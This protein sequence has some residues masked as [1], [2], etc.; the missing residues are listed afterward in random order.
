[1]S[2]LFFATLQNWDILHKKNQISSFYWKTQRISYTGPTLSSSNCS[3]Y[4]E[5]VSSPLHMALPT[6][7]LSAGNHLP[8]HLNIYVSG[9]FQCRNMKAYKIMSSITK[10]KPDNVL[11]CF[12]GKQ[13]SKHLAPIL[14]NPL[15]TNRKQW[16]F[17]SES[18]EKAWGANHGP[19]WEIQSKRADEL[20]KLPLHRP[21]SWGAAPCGTWVMKKSQELVIE[22]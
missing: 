3:L 14:K 4:T 12:I 10:W 5:K 6:V 15:C 18:W 1:M 7:M 11:L 9:T 22:T 16:N 8:L 17:S 13:I 21:D 2:L 20:R 19:W